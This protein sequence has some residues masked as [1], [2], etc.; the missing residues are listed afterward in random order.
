MLRALPRIHIKRPF[1]PSRKVY[2]SGACRGC[3]HVAPT[4]TLAF[5]QGRVNNP[6]RVPLIPSLFAVPLS[7]RRLYRL[8]W[9]NTRKMG[10]LSTRAACVTAKIS[11]YPPSSGAALAYCICEHPGSALPHRFRPPE[12]NKTRRQGANGGD[13]AVANPKKPKLQLSP[14]VYVDRHGVPPNRLQTRGRNHH[15]ATTNQPPPR[16]RHAFLSLL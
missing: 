4:D 15:S 8:P 11:N 10:Y 13:S 3:S 9:V 1:E 6:P 7:F 16:K 5:R 14:T 2:L 12:R